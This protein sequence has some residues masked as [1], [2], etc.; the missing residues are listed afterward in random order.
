M[1]DITTKVTETKTMRKAIFMMGG[2]ASGKTSVR[3]ERYADTLTIDSDEFKAAHPDY[4]PKNAS[5]L[6]A[7][8]SLEARKM[9]DAAV[10]D[11]VDFVY[12]GTGSTAEKYVD[13][14][15]TAKTA[16]Y[17]TEIIYVECDV[18]IALKRNAKRDRRVDEDVIIE[19]YELITTSFAIVSDYAD[20]VTVIAKTV[21]VRSMTWDLATLF[22]GVS[23]FF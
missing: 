19:K 9:F 13:L 22:D 1:N 17:E 8:S 10:A 3:L 23:K 16:G 12:D 6:H 15:E 11:G 20:K 14:I 18:H 7:W 21:A 4:D 5:A 2:P